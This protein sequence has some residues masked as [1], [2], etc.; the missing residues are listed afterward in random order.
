MQWASHVRAL[1]FVDMLP[2]QTPQDRLALAA[3]APFV[4]PSPGSLLGRHPELTEFSRQNLFT[5][6]GA[7]LLPVYASQYLF[8]FAVSAYPARLGG[9]TLLGL[10]FQAT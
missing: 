8:H 5:Y 7:N 10:L 4:L 9:Y 6:V 1:S 2:V 3:G